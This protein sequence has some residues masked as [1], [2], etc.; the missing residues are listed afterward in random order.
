MDCED[1]VVD[2][3]EGRALAEKHGIPFLETSAKTSH[4]I[5]ECFQTIAK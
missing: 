3:S 2:E 4:N 5:A 1:R